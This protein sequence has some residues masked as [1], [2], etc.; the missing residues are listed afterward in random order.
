MRTGLLGYL[1]CAAAGPT[2]AR[3][4]AHKRTRAIRFI[5]VSLTRNSS[6]LDAVQAVRGIL[7]GEEHDVAFRR[8]LAGMD[9]IGRDV[10][11]RSGPGLHLLVADLG[12]EGAF[13]H[14][15]PLL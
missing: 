13:Q 4:A 1:S 14:V 3:Q 9:H 12:L 8:R 2:P 7:H 11:E 10:D 15:D 6:G 5:T